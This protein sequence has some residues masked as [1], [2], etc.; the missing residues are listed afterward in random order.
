M[1]ERDLDFADRSG[2][3]G[4]SSRQPPAP[5]DGRPA[6]VALIDWLALFVASACTLALELL[7][8]RILSYCVDPVLVF[9]A[10][11][12]A[13][14]GTGGG[15]LVVA[16]RPALVG[17][18]GAVDDPRRAHIGVVTSLGAFALLVPATHLVFA[19]LV[20]GTAGR[21]W[22]ALPLLCGFALCYVASGVTSSVVLTRHA[23]RP[24]GAYAAMV[25]G[26]AFGAVAPQFLL[27][28]FGAE[29]AVA[30]IAF[31]AAV[32]TLALV[33][34]SPSS[35]ASRGLVAGAVAVLVWTMAG[36]AT[37]GGAVVFPPDPNDLLARAL[38]ASRSSGAATSGTARRVHDAW[39]P[40]G[41]VEVWEL[42]GRFGRVDGQPFRLFVQDAGAGSMLMPLRR[43]QA[44]RR[45]ICE[46]TVYGAGY[47]VR[48][49]PSRV[50]VIGLGG[51]PDVV[52][53]LHHEARAV[54]AVE[55]S[56]A[57][58]GA[59]RG[60]QARFL[61][62][63]LGDPRVTAVHEDGRAFLERS[64]ERFDLVQ[65]SGTDTYSA[66]ASGAFV[67]SESYL[68]TAEAFDRALSRLSDR[69]VLSIIR[70]GFEPFRIVSTA[71]AALRRAGVERPDRHI[72]IV[73]QGIWV[74]V[75][76]SR[77]PIEPAARERV[78]LASLTSRARPSPIVMPLYEA[79]GFG[80]RDP[81]VV[82]W[83]PSLATQN[84]YA[85][86]MRAVRRGEEGRALAALAL[87]FAP[88][89]DDRPFFFHHLDARRLGLLFE[90]GADPHYV[91]GLRQHLA[92]LAGAL[93]IALVLV[94]APALGRRDPSGGPSHR[95]GIAVVFG[96][97]GAGY[98]LIEIALLA[99]TGLLL[100]HP[101]HGAT[102]TIATLLASSGLGAVVLGP[103][104]RRDPLRATWL[105][106]I[107]LVAM[108]VAFEPL[109]VP[110]LRAALV[111]PLG[112]RVAILVL[113]VVPLGALMG[114]PF[115]AALGAAS[116]RG[117][118]SV[119]W[120]LG[121]NAFASVVASLGAV[122]IA[123]GGG[124]SSVLAAGAGAYVVATVA[125]AIALRR[126]TPDASRVA[127]A[128]SSGA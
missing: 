85:D 113:A 97:L 30:V 7:Q 72:V 28:S 11:G 69:G 10:I 91:R 6:R 50:L 13:L 108:L 54:T 121:V 35:R 38:E 24:H 47:L 61:G 105:T 128:P 70:F 56:G 126:L 64:G 32:A 60:S 123:M 25:L 39:D 84:A 67:F 76:V 102:L 19:L 41:R 83:V 14:L 120:A 21:V 122:P 114:V 103:F 80:L 53:A 15:A 104:A 88:I 100:G 23:H 52:C 77:S 9:S 66:A 99:K 115:P 2:A 12:V 57:V 93:V 40:V 74:A 95:W 51:A 87:D 22:A 124:F 33:V 37:G 117:P 81:L 119:A 116:S 82:D 36:L 5:L 75:V 106:V 96:A 29:R 110:T 71:V 44:L 89:V 73:R 16:M 20:A 46:T 58:L 94:V 86:L 27:S 112:A 127:S 1:A 98:L 48:P 31:V 8:L 62:D 17:L 42:P 4:Y 26:S 49:R 92:F 111:L 18:G 79:L 90:E 43:A 34:G 107:P 68:Y 125:H 78:V 118:S 3:T 63:P 45:A 59:L 109:V 101:A 55:L 65:M